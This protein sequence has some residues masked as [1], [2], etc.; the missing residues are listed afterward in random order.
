MLINYHAHLVLTKKSSGM[1][2]QLANGDVCTS[3]M[4]EL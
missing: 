1:K 4:V 2:S 3:Y